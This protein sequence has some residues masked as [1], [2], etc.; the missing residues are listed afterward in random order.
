[1][2][3][4]VR[5]VAVALG[6]LSLMFVGV[7]PAS[8][9]HDNGFFNFIVEANVNDDPA[10]KLQDPRLVAE[11]NYVRDLNTPTLDAPA[12][13]VDG[14]RRG[15]EC[16]YA[17][18]VYRGFIVGRTTYSYINPPGDGNETGIIDRFM[19]EAS[20]GFGLKYENGTPMENPPTDA[21]NNQSCPGG[22]TTEHTPPSSNDP[23]PPPV[24][25]RHGPHAIEVRDFVGGEGTGLDGPDVQ[26]LEEGTTFKLVSVSETRVEIIALQ[27]GVP[28]LQIL[29]ELMAPGWEVP[30]T[31]DAVTLDV[32]AAYNLQGLKA[33]VKSGRARIRGSI[34]PS[35]SGQKV[36][37]TFFA[38]GSA[39]RKVAAKDATL[40]VS[41][42]FRKRFKVPS[43]A[44]R[45]KVVVRFKG[46]TLG[47][48][49]FRC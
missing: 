5:L 34:H 46:A 7:G 27:D 11:F 4:S 42:G 6:S 32:G 36:K 47:Q 29:Y 19:H 39:L 24:T 41:S 17:F 28:V 2:R 22:A 25:F 12:G 14:D 3:R 13:W 40:G 30:G 10:P 15:Y 9:G 1:M 26:R 44:T 18:L 31:N 38:N 49:K 35:A 48:K 33:K 45:C 37:V 21:Q 23:P 20:E 16:G 43:D 8:A